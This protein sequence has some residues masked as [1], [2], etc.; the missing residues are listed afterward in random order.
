MSIIA[1]NGSP[2]A[3]ESATGMLIQ[4]VERMLG[5]PIETRQAVKL[6][7]EDASADMFVEL[8]Q[9][10]TLLIAFPL[11]VDSLPAPLIEILTRIEEAAASVKNKPRVYALC[12]CGF[13]E[14][15]QCKLALDMARHFA[16]RI[17]CP[18]GGGIGIG[19]GGMLSMRKDDLSRGP[20]APVYAGMLDICD[21][22]RDQSALKEDLLI[23]PSFPRFFYR[24]AGNMSWRRMARK[25]GVKRLL[26]AKPH[27]EE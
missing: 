2:K 19:C 23:S 22:I 3:R 8:L 18:W 7:R 20:M 12:N 25:N 26:R 10:E 14:G 21:A 11:Y 5:K 9:E 6:L 15:S 17:G 16:A 4:H 1:L 24:M 13:Y 27:M